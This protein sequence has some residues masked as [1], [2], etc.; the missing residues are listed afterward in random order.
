MAAAVTAGWKLLQIGQ[1][2][3]ADLVV[4]NRV[5]ERHELV[6]GNL[7]LEFHGPRACGDMTVWW[8]CGDMTVYD[9]SG[10]V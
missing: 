2:A 10:V 7:L 3:R 5:K 1:A 9:R 8:W 6:E 4:R